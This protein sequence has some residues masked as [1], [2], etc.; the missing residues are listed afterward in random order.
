MNEYMVIKQ[1]EPLIKKTIKMYVKHKEYYQDAYQ[2]CSLAIINAVRRYSS[3]K[4]N[5]TAYIKCTIIYSIKGFA[6]KLKENISLD[7]ELEDGGSLYELIPSDV[8]LEE[9]ILKVKI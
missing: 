8:D 7:E 5:F 1:Y 4:G 6:S 3:E 2:E 9:I